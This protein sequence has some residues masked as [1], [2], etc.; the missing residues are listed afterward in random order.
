[1]CGR[2]GHLVKLKCKLSGIKYENMEWLTILIF[3]LELN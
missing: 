3:N 2:Y 1:M